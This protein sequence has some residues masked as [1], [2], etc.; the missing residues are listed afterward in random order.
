MTRGYRV[1]QPEAHVDDDVFELLAELDALERARAERVS[2]LDTRAVL[3]RLADRIRAQFGFDV[4]LIGLVEGRDLVLRLWSGTRDSRLHDLPVPIGLGVGGR[5]AAAGSPIVVPNYYRSDRITHDFDAHVRAEGLGS[6]AA[7]PVRTGEV[8]GVLYG[9]VRGEAEVGDDA[10]DGLRGLARLAGLAVD[11]ADGAVTLADT[12]VVE[13]RRRLAASL[14]D[15]VGAMLFGVGSSV[16]KLREQAVPGVDDQ[17]ERIERQL[18]A[19]GMALRESISRLRVGSD[20]DPVRLTADIAESVHAF[21]QRAGV[22]ASFVPVG[23]TPR[24]DPARAALVKRVVDEGLLN[25]EKH[26]RARS[27]VVTLAVSDRVTV[28]VLDDGVGVEEPL[29]GTG[30]GLP[31]LRRQVERAGGALS[32]LTTEEGGA[33]LR[34]ELPAPSPSGEVGIV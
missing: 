6:M 30:A 14:H 15:S 33:V 34:C 26:A 25:V 13:E 4:S 1:A 16:R 5:V 7:V 10:V 8:R 21:T 17:L 19:A 22:A 32:L 29:G 28:A 2:L 3:R 27:V 20:R 18:A 31:A 11:V 23:G 24:L 9:A 12:A